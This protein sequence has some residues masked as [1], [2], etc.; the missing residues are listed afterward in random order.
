MTNIMLTIIG[1]MATKLL[2]LVSDKKKSADGQNTGMY[3]LVY[4]TAQSLASVHSCIW[5]TPS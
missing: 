3:I 5:L 2:R 4:P 1:R